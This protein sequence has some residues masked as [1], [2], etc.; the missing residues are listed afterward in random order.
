V[1]LFPGF[2]GEAIAPLL[3]RLSFQCGRITVREALSYAGYAS[4]EMMF[5]VMGYG[6]PTDWRGPLDAASDRPSPFACTAAIVA[7][8]L[9]LKVASIEPFRTTAVTEVALRVAAGEI[10]A[11]TVGAQKIGV[12][13]DCGR[14]TIVVEHVTWMDPNVAPEWSQREGYEIEFDGAPTLRCNLL[15]GTKGED[16]TD[17][18]CLA[19]A[20]HAVH[21]IPRVRAAPPG[22]LDLADV[23]PFVGSLA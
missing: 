13:A 11:G 4:R 8:A 14:I 21:A 1:G 3:S 7:K 16:H 6:R 17:M 2:W 22:L 18:G 5:D 15:L 12:L 10:P 19:T 23:P 20:M 9:G